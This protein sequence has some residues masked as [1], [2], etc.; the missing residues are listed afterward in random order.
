MANTYIMFNQLVS[1]N[2]AMCLCSDGKQCRCPSGEKSNDYV[3]NYISDVKKDKESIKSRNAYNAYEI[4]DAK[5]SLFRAM[6]NPELSQHV[7]FYAP[8]LVPTYTF[9]QK[10]SFSINLNANVNLIFI[11]R[12]VHGLKL[13]WVNI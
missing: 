6:I 11:F 4:F 2:D 8:F 9:N 5:I 1:K 3:E 7:R 10:T 12:D 13:I